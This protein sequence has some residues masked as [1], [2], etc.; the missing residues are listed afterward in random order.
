MVPLFFHLPPRMLICPPL[1]LVLHPQKLIHIHMPA[2]PHPQVSTGMLPPPH[3]THPCTLIPPPSG[4]AELGHRICCLS[5]SCCQVE[6]GSGTEAT[7]TPPEIPPTSKL[8]VYEGK[9]LDPEVPVGSFA[10]WALGTRSH[11]RDPVTTVVLL[12]F[13]WIRNAC[14]GHED[15]GAW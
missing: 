8:R 2:A 10:C 7:P 3:P 15:Q 14:V 13:L 4:L 9:V 6:E 11:S 12:L 5:H 1:P